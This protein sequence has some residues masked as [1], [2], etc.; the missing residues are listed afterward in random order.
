MKLRPIIA[1]IA[2]TASTLSSQDSGTASSLIKID[3]IVPYKSNSIQL[4]VDGELLHPKEMRGKKVSFFAVSLDPCNLGEGAEVRIKPRP[5][6]LRYAFEPDGFN[7]NWQEGWL[8]AFKFDGKE[9]TSCSEDSFG[10][11]VSVE[12]VVTDFRE[13]KYFV[14]DMLE[15]DSFAFI[16]V[17]SPR[18]FKGIKIDLIVSE[19]ELKKFPKI[20]DTGS[21]VSFEVPMR[22]VV[23]SPFDRLTISQ[24]ENFILRHKQ[25]NK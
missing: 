10:E 19:T 13:V 6:A 17:I 1:V 11:F 21:F 14:F 2:L 22:R 8:G 20:R 4:H 3:S 18:K 15:T 7:A 25:P 16:R 5:G 12:A 24:T 9:F 23:L